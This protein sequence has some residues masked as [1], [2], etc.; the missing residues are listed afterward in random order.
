MN[1]MGTSERVRGLVAVSGQAPAYDT[2]QITALIEESNEAFKKFK[3][4]HISRV[5]V[6]ENTVNAQ[7]E[8]IMG[9]RL[10]EGGGI[11]PGAGIRRGGSVAPLVGD[12]AS[13]FH[14]QLR[15][16]PSAS[17]TTQSGP[18][19]GFTVSPQVDSMI[20]GLLRDLSPLRTLA[21]VV[22]LTTGDSWEKLLG[23]TGS[24]SAWAGEQDEREDTTN[25][26]LGVVAIRPFEVYAIPSLTN[27]V[28]E[29]SSFDLNAFVSDDV[30]GE[31]A[32]IEGAAFV[33]GNGVKKPRG[34][35][36]YDATTELDTARAFGKLQYIA[37][38]TSGA[39]A[40]SNPADKLHDL[41]TSL[42]PAYRKGDGVAWLMNSTTANVIRKMKDG[43]GNYLWT[44]SIVA[45]QPDRLLGYPVALDEGMPDIAADTCAVAFGNWKRGYAIVDKPG[46]RLIVDRVT[47]KG[48]TKLYF[49]KRVGGGVVD[50]NAIKLLKFGTS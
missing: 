7:Q 5:D 38:G 13:G 41:L 23:R 42:K 17:M 48:W 10:G 27:H 47:R 31:F 12:V 8:T 11:H 29:D 25:P 9:L 24:Q 45:G 34:F 16:L 37:T 18:D 32:L 20:D 43:Q 4:H 6:L 14:D 1:R 28:I 46:L 36:S 39:F 26:T 40:G 2:A 33:S 35:L 15:G 50:S 22:S 44:N 21:R 49:S 19:G 3:S 30:A